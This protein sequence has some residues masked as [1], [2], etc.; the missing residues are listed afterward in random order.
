MKKRIL[1]EDSIFKKNKILIP[2]VLILVWF[3]LYFSLESLSNWL[4]W[5]YACQFFV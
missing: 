1:E 4:V 5:D 2:I 3:I